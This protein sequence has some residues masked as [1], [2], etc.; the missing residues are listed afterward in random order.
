MTATNQIIIKQYFTIYDLKIINKI[1]KKNTIV[2]RESIMF[3]LDL[4][5]FILVR[6]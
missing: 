5:E 3:K 2:P 1:K 6:K 4:L